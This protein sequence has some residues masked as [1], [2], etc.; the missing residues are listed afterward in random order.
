[1]KGSSLKKSLRKKSAKPIS[2]NVWARTMQGSTNRRI[3]ILGKKTKQNQKKGLGC[4]LSLAHL[5]S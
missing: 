5:N 4:G 3:A 2:T 1:M